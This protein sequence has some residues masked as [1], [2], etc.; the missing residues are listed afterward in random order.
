MPSQRPKRLRDFRFN[1]TQNQW[2][3]LRVWKGCKDDGQSSVFVPVNKLLK[4]VPKLTRL[5]LHNLLEDK[6]TTSAAA[7]MCEKAGLD[8]DFI[9]TGHA[10]GLCSA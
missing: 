4:L 1:E 2:E 6:M 10:L 8:V 7:S 3:V 9:K 5:W